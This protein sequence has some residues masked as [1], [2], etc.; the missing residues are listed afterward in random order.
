M[1]THKIRHALLL[2]SFGLLP[3][4]A[5]AH[6]GHDT[7]GMLSGM[8]HPLL[9]WD[10]L[11][12]MV[13]VGMLAVMG[14]NK[15]AWQLPLAF[16]GF[17]LIGALFGMNGLAIPAVESGILLSLVVLGGLLALGRTSSLWV[18]TVC[19]ALFGTLHG[20]AHGIELPAGKGA[21]SYVI[22][23]TLATIALHTAGYVVATKWQTIALRISGVAIAS[24][25]VVAIISAV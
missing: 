3:S 16:V 12:A 24:I 5:F 6:P 20:N 7:S 21:V 22:G 4:V 13:A 18:L 25:G 23:F 1:N 2:A 11:L 9:G 14:R 19:C 10:H 8:L 17:M 15:P